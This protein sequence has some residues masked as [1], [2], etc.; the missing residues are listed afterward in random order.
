MIHDPVLGRQKPIHG[1]NAGNKL[2]ELLIAEHGSHRRLGIEMRMIREFAHPRRLVR[3]H[4]FRLQKV[5]PLRIATQIGKNAIEVTVF[6]LGRMHHEGGRVGTVLKRTSRK[7]RKH[8]SEV[9]A[10]DFLLFSMNKKRDGRSDPIN[11][12]AT[13]IAAGDGVCFDHRVDKG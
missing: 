12:T 10:H 6:G 13:S 3:H 2:P 7:D 4:C 9:T 5:R 11:K 1:W 8:A